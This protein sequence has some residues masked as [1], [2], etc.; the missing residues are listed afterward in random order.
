MMLNSK[1]THALSSMTRIQLRWAAV[2]WALY[3]TGYRSS[4]AL[5]ESWWQMS[6]AALIIGAISTWLGAFAKSKSTSVSLKA[7]K[8]QYTKSC[9]GSCKNF[10]LNDHLSNKAILPK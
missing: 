1:Q 2:V 10:K 8:E 9:R 7:E 3:F 5:R 6:L 4:I